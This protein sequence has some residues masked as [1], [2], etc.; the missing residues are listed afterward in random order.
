MSSKINPFSFS[1][2]QYELLQPLIHTSKG[3]RPLRVYF[4]T[5]IS[6]WTSN[7]DAS[8]VPISYLGELSK[9][10]NRAALIEAIEAG[11]E[12]V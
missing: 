10:S 2:V 6:V 4:D 9:D 5:Y 12:A 8:S 3:A 1:D 11:G 7:F